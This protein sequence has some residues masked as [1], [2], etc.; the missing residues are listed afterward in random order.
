MTIE[1]QAFEVR[2]KETMR[3]SPEQ[4]ESMRSA[5]AATFG[6]GAAVG[7]RK[8]DLVIEQPGDTRPFVSVAHSAGIQL[9]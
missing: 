4:V 6:N 7:E 1:A 2:C 8:I 3:L 9:L 5:A